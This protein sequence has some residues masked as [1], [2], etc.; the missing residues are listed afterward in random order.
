MDIS[1]L[2]YG[3]ITLI[4]KVS[5][6][7]KIQQFRPIC[8]LNRLYKW[9]TKVLTLRISPYAEKL[10]CI[11]QSAFRKGRNIMNGVMALHEILHETKRHKQTGVILKLDFEKAYDKVDWNS[12]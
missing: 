9:V 1:R 7:S 8:L 10:I 4:P 5:D 3:I 12:L 6:A 11:E 2:N